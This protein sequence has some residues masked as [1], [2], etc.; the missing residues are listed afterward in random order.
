MDAWATGEEVHLKLNHRDDKLQVDLEIW[1]TLLVNMNI[2]RDGDDEQ[3]AQTQGTESSNTQG[4]NWG[5]LDRQ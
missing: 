5:L 2:R 3:G 4:H 1:T